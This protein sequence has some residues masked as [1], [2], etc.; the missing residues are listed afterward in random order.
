MPSQG[1]I[2]V[3]G[4]GLA[5]LS[6]ALQLSRAGYAVTVYE[7][8]GHAGGRCRSF[9]DRTLQRTIDNGAHLMLGA[10]RAL[11]AYVRS[12]D[13]GAHLNFHPPSFAFFDI[14]PDALRMVGVRF[15]G[16]P[17][18]II[19]DGFRLLLS[20]RDATVSGRLSKSR[21]F[22]PLWRPLSE[23]VLNTPPE[24]ASAALLSRVL[25]LVLAGGAKAA[26]PRLA[27]HGLGPA[28]IDPAVCALERSGCMLRYHQRLR[29]LQNGHPV[30]DGTEKTH[31][32]T[33]LALPHHET[34]RLLPELPEI[35]SH[36]I[37]NAH[38]RL[39]APVRLPRDV[40]FLGLTGGTAHWLFARD[41]VLSVT[42]SA[43]DALSA[44]SNDEIAALLWDDASRALGLNASRL[45]MVR[46]SV[47]PL[48]RIVRERRATIA[49]TPDTLR[50]RPE[51]GFYR[52][53]LYLAGDWTDTALPCTIEG[54]IVSGEK[55]A[56]AVMKN[57]APDTGR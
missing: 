26:R 42:V 6:C 1:G 13:A 3:I 29:G 2:A 14:G 55:A 35:P 7:A 18:G 48:V 44:C 4:A 57:I 49:Q 53:S 25:R 41:D 5:G 51:P 15:G 19:P 8:A 33:V 47:R 46:P 23:S 39:D 54:A 40:P 43:A 24:E 50:L 21:L 31:A 11:D 9:F 16:F 27:A 17:A 56:R 52:D 30:F 37:V 20:P 34:R 36:C 10:N 38:F 28:L 12:I 22:A 45:P 32:A